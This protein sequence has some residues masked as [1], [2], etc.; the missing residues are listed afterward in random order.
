LKGIENEQIGNSEIERGAVF[1]YKT[2]AK[3][4]GRVGASV[5]QEGQTRPFR[6][7]R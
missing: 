2:E 4:D 1:G 3:T 5:V 6:S 7:S